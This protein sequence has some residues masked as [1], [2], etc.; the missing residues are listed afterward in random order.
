MRYSIVT[1]EHKKD[2][3][4]VLV[5]DHKEDVKYMI[6]AQF[7]DEGEEDSYYDIMFYGAM[8]AGSKSDMYQRSESGAGMLAFVDAIVNNE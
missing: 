6:Y 1:S 8:M 7:I 2:G 3:Y 5:H 4:Y